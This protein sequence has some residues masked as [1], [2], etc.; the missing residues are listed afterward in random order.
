MTKKT[1]K[2]KILSQKRKEAFLL[3]QAYKSQEFIKEVKNI[4]DAKPLFNSNKESLSDQDFNIRNFF[5]HDFK[6]SI[7][8]IALIIA[9]EIVLYFGTINKYFN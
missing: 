2:Q 7:F 1:K 9:L 8:I 5:I 4:N 6:K 3:H